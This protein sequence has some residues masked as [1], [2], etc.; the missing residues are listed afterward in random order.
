MVKVGVVGASGFV[1]RRAVEMLHEDGMTV[2]PIVRQADSLPYFTQMGLQGYVANAFDQAALEQAFSGCDVVIHSILGSAGLIRGSVEPAYR[3]AQNA[4][5][6]RLIYLSSMIVHTSAPDPGTTEATPPIQHQPG[7]PTHIAKIDAER[8]LLKLQ[9]AGSVEVVIFRPGIVFGPRSRW[10]NELADQFLQGT[11]Y[12]IHDGR[13]ICN[14]VYVDNLI[15]AMRLAMFAE[16]VN[17]EAFFVG[18]REQVTW[19]DFYHPFARALGVDPH[20][21]PQVPPPIFT[22]SKKQEFLRSIRESEIVQKS[23]A[24]LSNDLKQ[25]MKRLIPK[26]SHASSTT[27]STTLVNPEPI[28]TEMMAILQQSQ[29]KLPLA[30][31][32]QRLGYQPIVS[33]DQGCRRSI[34]WMMQEKMTTGAIA[35]V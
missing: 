2:C 35:K 27:L 13:G 7:F 1:G 15:H 23:L 14:T 6:R 11:A 28:V 21:I 24:F 30:K 16:G 9:K 20:T 17:G 3:A 34:E 25:S 10:I 12:F 18:D 33:F 29:Y 26:Q 5:V 32:E 31:A 22:H 8:K 4:G 19:F